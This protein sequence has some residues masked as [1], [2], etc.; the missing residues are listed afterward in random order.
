MRKVIFCLIVIVCFTIT[1]H[2]GVMPGPK[3]I[4]GPYYNIGNHDVKLLYFVYKGRAS[5]TWN[6]SFLDNYKKHTNCHL[7]DGH[8]RYVTNNNQ[9]FLGFRDKDAGKIAWVLVYFSGPYLHWKNSGGKSGSLDEGESHKFKYS[10]GNQ[11]LYLKIRNPENGP[12]W[13]K[14][15]MLYQ[16]YVKNE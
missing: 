14:E 3:W 16:Y 4:E 9:V 2:A 1:A 10:V 11:K 15:E 12:N 13:K 6:Q 7:I 5:S 8:E